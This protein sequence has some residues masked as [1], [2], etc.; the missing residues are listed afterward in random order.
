M[1]RLLS[2]VMIASIMLAATGCTEPEVEQGPQGDEYG[3]VVEE[4]KDGEK[5]TFGAMKRS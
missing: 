2:V 1:K 3:I 5:A 4:A